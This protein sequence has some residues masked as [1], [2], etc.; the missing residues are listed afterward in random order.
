MLRAKLHAPAINRNIIRRE[1][2]LEKLEHAKDGKLTLVTAPAGYGKTTAVLDWLGKCGLPYAWLSLDSRD[3]D[4]LTFWQYVCAALDGLTG[5][6]AKDV[7]YVFSSSELM[8]AEIHIRILI[9]RLSERSSDFLLVLD[10]LQRIST[11]SILTGLSYLIDYLTAVMGGT[12][13]GRGGGRGFLQQA[14]RIC[15]AQPEQRI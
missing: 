7:E 2:L 1:K 3:N 12:P 11:P 5:G 9:D 14:Y 15:R 6:I 8:K 10:D 13:S 4:P